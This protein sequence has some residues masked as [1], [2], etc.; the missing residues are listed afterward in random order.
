MAKIGRKLSKGSKESGAKTV[1]G[2]GDG[3]E[4]HGEVFSHGSAG[5]NGAGDRK[6]AQN[7]LNM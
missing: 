3:K 6:V 1:S 2:K 5:E 7:M 4:G